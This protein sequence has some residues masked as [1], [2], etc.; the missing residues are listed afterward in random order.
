MRRKKSTGAVNSK[1][2]TIDGITFASSLE[3][4]TYA[5]LKEAGIDF[6]YEGKTFEVLPAFRYE[7]QYLHSTSK[8]KEMSDKTG[9][10]V[11]AVTYKPDFVGEGW[12]IE[13][14]GF[15]PSNHSF[16]LRL[17]M[18]LDSIKDQN[19]SVY[20]PKNQTQVNE[21]IEHIKNGH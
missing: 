20:I 19:I 6:E 21:V 12:V 3:A 17:K 18:F 1:K 8:K 16:P 7:A 15:V 14:K 5:K 9:K 4:Y 2:K 13:C 11:R 10:L